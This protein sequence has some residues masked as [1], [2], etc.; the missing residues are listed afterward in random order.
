VS[1]IL[2]FKLHLSNFN[3]WRFEM[4]HSLKFSLNLRMVYA[5]KLEKEKSKNEHAPR[6]T[7]T[8]QNWFCCVIDVDPSKS[9]CSPGDHQAPLESTCWR[10]NVM[11]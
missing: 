11:S 6:G 4:R 10:H 9:L 3:S 1:N 8:S 2:G 7:I 5:S